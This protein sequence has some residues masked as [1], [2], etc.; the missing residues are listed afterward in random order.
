MA[1]KV[2]HV[3]CP[4]CGCCCDDI[5]VTVDKNHIT[6]VRNTCTIGSSKFLDYLTER[7]TR[8]LLRK[9]GKAYEASLDEAVDEAARILLN[10]KYPLLY[11]WSSTCSEAQ[12][13]GVELAERVGG[14]LDNT[15][16]VCHGPTIEAV[17]DVG[18]S[19]ATLGHIRNRSDLLVFWGCNP[20]QAHIRHLIR[21][22]SSSKGKFISGRKDRKIVVVDV[23]R[24]TTART[25][26]LFLKVTP[27]HDYELI[28]ALRM[29][30][31]FEE[32]LEE[33]VAGVP[34]FQIEE[35]AEMMRG[36]KFG[37]FL[38]GL[39]LT[40]T[41]GR[42]RNIEAAISLVRDLNKYTKFVLLPM[43]GHFNVTG[44]NKVSTW[45]TGYPFAVDFSQGYPRYN[46][47]ETSAA[48]LLARKSCD[49]LCVIASD[50]ISNFPR[51]IVESMSNIPKIVID[52]HMTPTGRISNVY[53]PTAAVGLETEGTIYRMDGV[54]LLSKKLVDPPSGVPT[55]QEVLKMILNRVKELKEEM[56]V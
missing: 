22:S 10:A 30:I 29:A 19:T 31:G 3:V 43:R 38:F 20:A 14:V 12:R 54:P 46:P 21:Y 44:A 53:I 7:E 42:E 17:Q 26:D 11:G 52:P 41:R 28:T 33:Q 32:I 39:G 35:L 23:R 15:S 25:A 37:S 48:D 4:F 47:G 5:Q 16:S 27:N 55:D 1:T 40:M 6:E 2:E 49:A 8:P 36:C 50:P 34:V 18:E 45:Q 24:T 56:T 9:D 13:V 51:E